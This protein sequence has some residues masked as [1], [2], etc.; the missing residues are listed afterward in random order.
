MKMH[1]ESN[2]YF[3]EKKDQHG[4][5]LGVVTL[6]RSRALNA[7]T[8]DMFLALEDQLLKWRDNDQIKAVLVKSNSDR[9]FC[10]GGDIRAVYENWHQPLSENTKYFSLEY[11]INPL[12]YNYPKPYIALLDGI[13]MGGGAGISIHGS[14]PVGTERLV[15]AM[16]ETAIGFFPDVGMSYHLSRMPKAIG[17]YLG[18]SGEGVDIDDASYLGIVKHAVDSDCLTALENKIVEASFLPHDFDAVSDLISSFERSITSGLLQTNQDQIA[19]HFSQNNLA[20][21]IHSLANGDQWAVAA[22]DVLKKRSP[23]SLEVT[24]RQLSEAS[25]KSFDEVM[26]TDKK[27]VKK[28][29]QTDDFYEGIRAMVIDKDKQPKWC[30]DRLDQLSEDQVAEYF[31]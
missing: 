3:E 2:I 21:V 1:N 6:N 4:M 18:L 24:W 9:A 19:Q 23:T 8:Y 16:P 22:L 7:L 12:I 20:A 27:L 11:R 30:P 28:F 31:R 29:L 13:T 14:H 26:V 17:I 15:F 10:A 5:K 25:T